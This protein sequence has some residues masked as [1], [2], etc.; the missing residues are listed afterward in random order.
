MNRYKLKTGVLSKWAILGVT[1]GL[2]G[3]IITTDLD[4]LMDKV[5]DES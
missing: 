4:D 2:V 1:I 3:A 5:A